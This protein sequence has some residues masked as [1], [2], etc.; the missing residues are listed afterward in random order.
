[1]AARLAATA[2]VGDELSE[3]VQFSVKQV[4]EHVAALE[5]GA[6]LGFERTTSSG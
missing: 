1:M 6:F 4:R 3:S 2:L 5:R